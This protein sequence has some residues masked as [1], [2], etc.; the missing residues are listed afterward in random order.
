MQGGPEASPIESIVALA[1][2]II[3]EYP[4]CASRA[5][6]IIVWAREIG[7]RRSSQEEPAALVEAT[8]QGSCRMLG[9]RLSAT[10]YKP[11]CALRIEHPRGHIGERGHVVPFALLTF[12]PSG[13]T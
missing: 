4:S 12:D 6:E 10:A 5:S 2:A 1:N 11:L 8:G 13:C 3:D 9:G 7:E